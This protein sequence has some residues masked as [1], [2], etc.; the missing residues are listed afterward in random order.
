MTLIDLKEARKATRQPV[1][2]TGLI[3]FG[4]ASMGCVLRNLSELGA[5]LDI[6]P[7]K[8]IPDQFTLIVL[9]TKKIH[10]CSVIWRKQGRIGVAF[11]PDML[12]V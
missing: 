6:G 5:A 2:D 10:S 3:K 9:A 11:F 7:Q 1:L 4:D 12:T 8:G